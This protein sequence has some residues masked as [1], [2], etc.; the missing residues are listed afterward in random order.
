MDVSELREKPAGR[1]PIDTRTVSLDRLEEVVDAVGRAVNDG[2]R[3]YWICPLV[4]ESELVD[5]AAAEERFR[6]LKSRF[7][8]KVGLVHGQMR[9]G[10]RDDAMAAFADGATP[11]LVSTTVVEVG[12]DV[13]E[14]TVMVI[15][16]AERFGLAQL[17]QL[18]GRVGRGRDQSTC[19]LLYK[20]PLGEGAKRRLSKLRE[21]DDGFAIAEED[22]ALR[23]EGEVLGTRQSGLPGFRI[24]R[25]EL[26]RELMEA[27]RK[28]AALIVTR[29]PALTSERGRALRLLLHLF[30][31]EE[32]VRLI[33]AG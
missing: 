25:P 16:Q 5:L 14:A 22:L 18:R 4:E 7:G 11:I 33:E 17:H 23:G 19:L 20:G 12:V 21:T 29:D 13:P 26:H 3:A 6:F 24:A 8:N 31:R 2:A 15:E 1:T 32:A 30:D 10:E 28:D 9:P 27:A